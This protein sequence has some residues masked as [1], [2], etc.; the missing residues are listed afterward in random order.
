MPSIRNSESWKKLEDH[1]QDI[2]KKRILN[3]FEEDGQRAKSFS[4]TAC[5]LHLDFSK[6]LITEETLNLLIKLAKTAHLPDQ[7]KAMFDGKKINISENRRV[8]HTALRGTHSV[9]VEEGRSHNI[10]TKELRKIEIFSKKFLSGQ[11]VGAFG[12]PLETVVNIGIG[13]SDLGSKL[14]VEALEK[15]GEAIPNTIFLSNINPSSLLHVLKRISVERTLFII[16][17]KSF[18]TTETLTNSQIIKNLILEKLKQKHINSLLVNRHFC[19]VTQNYDLARKMGISNERI[20]KIWDWV[21]GRYSVWSSMGLS[22]A[23]SLGYQ[24]FKKLL[25]GANRMDAHFRST[26]W[27]KN[28][29][30]LLALISIWNRNFL[31]YRTHA[32]LPYSDSLALMPNYLQQLSMESNGKN[33]DRGG[34]KISYSTGYILWGGV[35]TNFQ[36][37]FGQH[38]HQGSEVTP[39]DF[40][41]PVKEVDSHLGDLD[42]EKSFKILVANC[43]AQSKALMEGH[44]SD[45]AKNNKEP[46]GKLTKS[47]YKYFPGNRP[48]NTIVMNELGPETLGALIAMYEHKVFCEGAIWNINSFDQWGVE[49][50]KNLSEHIIHR[51]E[52]TS[53][54]KNL[55]DQSTENLLNVIASFKK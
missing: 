52:K 36:H 40:I 17:S 12:K 18:E 4:T 13:G 50:G 38:L 53:L 9:E 43:L 44:D 6:N 26:E 16:S 25:A 30:V 11:L 24:K 51:M 2:Y 21:G 15:R 14:V 27:H 35:G 1:S 8:L 28:L 20:F 23:L 55:L 7:I 31:D 37:A 3:L 33:T 46:D 49:L 32:V 34:K 29:P 39:V 41:I 48:S 42:L 45:H 19:A 5:G 47:L 54:K 10:I 22:I